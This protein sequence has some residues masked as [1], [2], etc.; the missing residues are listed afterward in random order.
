MCDGYQ[1]GF[2]RSQGD[3]LLF[4]HDDVEFLCTD[5]APRLITHLSKFDGVGLAGTD[6]LVG[7][8]WHLAGPPHTFGQVAHAQKDCIEVDL[9]GPEKLGGIQAM[10]GVFMAFRRSL[11]EKIGWDAETFA[12]FHHY[13]LDFSF[14]AFKAGANLAVVN[15]LPVLHSSG[16]SYDAA[17]AASGEKFMRKHNL[18]VV[19]YP[20]CQ[21]AW[22]LVATIQEALGVLRPTTSFMTVNSR[23]PK[24]P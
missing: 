19:A 21:F 4:S 14:R 16:G 6:R 22:I 8:A 1:R 18:P 13:D 7:P 5:F 10:D 17:W 2:A 15:D 24:A 11:V 9:F 23:G 3:L 20:K 12:A